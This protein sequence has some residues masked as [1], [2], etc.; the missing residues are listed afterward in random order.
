MSERRGRIHEKHELSK[1]RR[2]ELLDVARSSAYYRGEPVSEADLAVM[3]L[4]DEIHLQWPFY[5]SRRM[6]DELEERGHTVNRKRVQRLMRQMDLRPCIHGVERASRARGT[7]FTP[8]CSGTCP[9]SARTRP[10]QVTSP[11]SPWPRGSCTWWRSWTGILAG[12][13]HGGCRTPW[14]RTSVSKPWRKLYSALKRRRS[15]IPTKVSRLELHDVDLD[16]CVLSIRQHCC[17]NK[18]IEGRCNILF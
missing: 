9:S 14:I 15:S 10:G 12:C 4:I 17:P 7:R 6:R 5:G 16:R 1:T 2:C 13:C 11:T 18:D 3:R 8:T